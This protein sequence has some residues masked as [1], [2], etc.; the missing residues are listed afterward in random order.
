MSCGGARSGNSGTNDRASEEATT[1]GGVESWEREEAG[2][3]FI[4]SEKPFILKIKLRWLIRVRVKI[5]RCLY[6][7]TRTLPGG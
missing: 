4:H 7:P 5:S 2:A 6:R 3:R 1:R